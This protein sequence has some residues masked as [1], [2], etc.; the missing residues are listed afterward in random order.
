MA[1]RLYSL[2]SIRILAMKQ[3]NETFNP[4]CLSLCLPFSLYSSDFNI[5]SAALPFY[6]APR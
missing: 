6:N 1:A 2:W 3:L 4:F 5:D